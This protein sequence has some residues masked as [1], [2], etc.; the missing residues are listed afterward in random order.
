MQPFDAYPGNGQVLLGPP[1]NS[2]NC[3]HGYG[4]DLQRQTGQTSCAYCGLNLVDEYAHWLLLSVDH[5][6][7]RGQAAS[8]GIDAVYSEDLINL[9][10]CC[11]GCNGFG[12]RYR[13]PL[14]AAGRGPWD[15]PMFVALRDTVFTARSVAIAARRGAELA[16]YQSRPWERSPQRSP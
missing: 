13:V 16:F 2:D 11:A 8:L 5:V 14:P 1:R 3:R 7:P 12:N 10:L 4:L 6:V 9:V 15:L